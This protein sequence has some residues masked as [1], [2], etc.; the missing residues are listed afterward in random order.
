MLPLT[1]SRFTLASHAGSYEDWPLKTN[2]LDAGQPTTV[3]L[4]G[5]VLRYQFEVA[6]GFL[7][8]TDWDCPYEESTEF[9]LLDRQLRLLQRISQNTPYSS[10]FI[11]T[12]SAIDQGRFLVLFGPE[13]PW[14]LTLRSE[15]T[16]TRRRWMTLSRATESGL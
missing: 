16:R 1:L 7:L 2:L 4:P 12:M 5:Y 6:A 15:L 9:I 3:E 11:D 10:W 14:V 13:D 8:V